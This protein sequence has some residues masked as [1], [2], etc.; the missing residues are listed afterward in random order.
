MYL[1]IIIPT[2]NEADNLPKLLS[3]LRPHLPAGEILVIDAGS[4][5]GTLQVA[6]QHGAQ[7]FC[8]PKRGRAA[9][10][11]Y[12]ASLAKGDVLYFVHADTVPPESYYRD[13]MQA[14]S[15]GAQV[16]S[17]RSSFDTNHLCMR[18]NAYMTRYDRLFCRGGD[19]SIATTRD[20]FEQVGGYREDYLIMEDFDFI[21]KA[22]KR[23]VFQIFPKDILIS[24]R[25]YT[26]NSYLRVNL[27][28]LTIVIMYLLG[29]SQP[30][31]VKAYKWMLNYR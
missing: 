13:I 26:H 7:A 18:V 29:A 20:F 5:D 21:Q 24:A 27:A 31:M 14:I 16:G 12:G 6:Q 25:K 9:Q 3:R 17:Y 4:T 15:S 23:E 19:Q 1:S 22:R 10:M 28:N 11:N 8:A 2:L 30:R